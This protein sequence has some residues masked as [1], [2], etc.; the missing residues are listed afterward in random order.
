MKVTK[1]FINDTVAYLKRV[2]A[3]DP[4]GNTM[5]VPARF[6][7]TAWMKRYALK[8]GIL[9]IIDKKAK[10]KPHT[11]YSLRP[12]FFSKKVATND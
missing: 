7:V 11:D 4:S 2:K 8:R 9:I 5:L 6:K 1:K 3:V 10:T 12:E